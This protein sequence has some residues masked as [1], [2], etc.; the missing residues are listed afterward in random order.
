M[1]RKKKTLYKDFS[2]GKP[3]KYRFKGKKRLG[4]R[5]NKVVEVTEFK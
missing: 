5:R 2:K 4:F 3:T 1:K